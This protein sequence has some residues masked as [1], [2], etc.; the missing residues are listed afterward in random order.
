MPRS[1]QVTPAGPAHPLP[2]KRMIINP[3]A[4]HTVR[5]RQ[6]MLRIQPPQRG[7]PHPDTDA[8]VDA[9]IGSR[10]NKFNSFSEQSP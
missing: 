8:T 7:S 4:T 1:Y 3:K 9:E 2:A 5:A 6:R 10:F